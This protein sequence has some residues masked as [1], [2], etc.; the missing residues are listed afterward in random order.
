MR[1]LLPLFR[2]PSHY[3]GCEINSVHKDPE[4]VRLR[5]GLAFPDLYEVGMSYLGQ[6]ILYH[7][8]N[9]RSDIWAE[10]VFAPHPEVAAVLREHRSPLCALESDT[11]IGNLDILGFSLTHELCYTTVLFMLDLGGIPF[12]SSQRDASHP[13]LVGG[14]DACFNPEPIAPFFDCFLVGEG[15]EAALEISQAIIR[16]KQESAS[17][18]QLLRALQGLTGVYVPGQKTEDRGQR[19]EERSQK[20]V[21]SS[22]K[23]DDRRQKTE[24]R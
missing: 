15:E 4:Q 1:E 19:T 12:R 13:L 24:D 8:L 16:A 14:G 3:L 5:W 23:T 10:R 6:K 9:A 7:Q 21:V 18:L 2:Q 17:R 20:S 11:P 22:Q